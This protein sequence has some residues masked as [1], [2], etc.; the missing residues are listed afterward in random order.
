MRGSDSIQGREQTE[1]RKCF[2]CG[3]LDHLK[4]R[5]PKQVNCNVCRT[6]VHTYKACFSQKSTANKS[7]AEGEK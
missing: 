1:G 5:C 7:C 6:D 4:R 2:K 3:V